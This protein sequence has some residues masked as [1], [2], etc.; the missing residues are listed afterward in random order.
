MD[1]IITNTINNL[2]HIIW[3]SQLLLEPKYGKKKT[4]VLSFLATLLYQVLFFAMVFHGFFGDMAYLAGYLMATMAFG[5]VYIFILSKF[6]PAKSLFVISAY[7]CLW[8]FIYGTISVV[9]ESYA[10]AGNLAIWLLRILLNVFFWYYTGSFC[11]KSFCRLLW[12]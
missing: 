6:H 7:F 4:V 5:G 1:V 2:F 8:T 12:R 3:I 9:T 10:G 11:R